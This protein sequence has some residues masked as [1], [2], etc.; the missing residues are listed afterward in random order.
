MR[1]IE[2]SCIVDAPVAEVFAFHRD[3]RN[4]ASI[5]PVGTQVLAVEGRFPVEQGDEVRLTIR[6]LPIPWPQRWRILIERV[7]APTLV[8][9]RMLAGPFAA[10]RHEHRFAA[11]DDGRT[12]L[13]DAVEY[14]VPLGA[15]GRVADA[16]VLRH[17]LRLSFRARHRATQRVL[18]QASSSSIQHS[19]Q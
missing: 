6:Q 5:S 19:K 16:L 3:T 12:M 8:V 10:W 18:G 17:A 1:R 7:Q 15:L 2:L 9:D 13:T 11:R 14:T 4:V